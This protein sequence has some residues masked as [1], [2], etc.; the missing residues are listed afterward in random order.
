MPK[1]KKLSN[2][3]RESRRVQEAEK[4]L[5]KVNLINRQ[6]TVISNK[7]NSLINVTSEKETLNV[8]TLPMKQ[9]KTDLI[10]NLAFMV[11]AIAV[12]MVLKV[13]NFGFDQL[14]PFLKF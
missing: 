14:R 3:D 7:K 13:T 9:I 2:T 5:H 11:F 12:L 6:T 8:Y 10:A 1:K 4:A